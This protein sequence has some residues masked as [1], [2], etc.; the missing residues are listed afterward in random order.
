MSAVTY[1]GDLNA[2]LDATRDEWTRA[3]ADAGHSMSWEVTGDSVLPER[4]GTCRRCGGQA[5]IGAGEVNGTSGRSPLTG[6]G[7]ESLRCRGRQ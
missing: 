6:R 1:T 7:D 4:L 3:L 5:E 2:S